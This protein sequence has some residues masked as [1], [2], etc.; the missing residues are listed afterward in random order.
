MILYKFLYNPTNFK[1]GFFVNFFVDGEGLFA[2][3]IYIL[4]IMP[5]C[6]YPWMPFKSTFSCGKVCA[7]IQKLMGFYVKIAFLIGKR[8]EGIYS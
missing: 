4:L 5:H 1:W 8:D 2:Y 3:D 7:Y 6:R